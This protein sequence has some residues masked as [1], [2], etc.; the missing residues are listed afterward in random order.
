[1]KTTI[2]IDQWRNCVH[3]GVGNDL[4]AALCMAYIFDRYQCQPLIT[5]F[6]RS[7]EDEYENLEDNSSIESDKVQ[8]DEFDEYDEDEDEDD[9]DEEKEKVSNE[10]EPLHAGNTNHIAESNN[11]GVFHDT[12][13]PAQQKKSSAFADDPS[14][15]TTPF[16]IDDNDNDNDQEDVKSFKTAGT[17]NTNN[18][19]NKKSSNSNAN[20]YGKEIEPTE[21][22]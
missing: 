21:I 3:A 6:G 1:M 8:N 18:N 15:A 5:V 22:V 7:E 11:D 2:Q 14:S 12:H 9:D 19:R 4:L 16:V 13:E 17:A 10:E 20:P